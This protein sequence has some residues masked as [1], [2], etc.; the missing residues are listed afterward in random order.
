MSIAKS[1]R[2]ISVALALLLL[3]A[4]GSEEETQPDS[5]TAADSSV[6]AADTTSYLETM[7]VHDF[8]G[9]DFRLLVNSQSDRPN[10]HAGELNGEVINDAM[11]L[12]LIHI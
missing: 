5:A 10:L 3:S 2:I 6:T 1:T 8:G 7:P 12:S 9:A 4:C 11:Y